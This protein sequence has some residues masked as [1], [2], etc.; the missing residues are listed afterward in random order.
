MIGATAPPTVFPVPL[1]H[2]RMSLSF[3][4]EGARGLPQTPT[5][6]LDT[7]DI[8]VPGGSIHAAQFRNLTLCSG[9]S[10]ATRKVLGL[11]DIGPTER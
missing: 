6:A 1:S 3:R 2:T 10:G 8:S 11:G 5:F 4:A 7:G 9:Q